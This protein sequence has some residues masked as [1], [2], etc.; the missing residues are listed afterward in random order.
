MQSLADALG[1]QDP[2]DK[3][4]PVKPVPFRTSAKAFA[5]DIVSSS[6]YRESIARRV[7]MDELPPAVEVLLLHY[8]YGKPVERLEVE[9]TSTD[10]SAMSV[11][12]LES[13]A[14]RLAGLAR[15]LRAAADNTPEAEIVGNVNDS[16]QSVH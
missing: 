15:T 3:E 14:L 5:R 13:R 11:E 1:C 12:Q 2:L 4:K 6:T 16:A 8:A 7:L 9:T 10:L